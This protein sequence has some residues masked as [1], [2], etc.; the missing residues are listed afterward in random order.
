VSFEEFKNEFENQ[1]N[2]DVDFKPE[3]NFRDC[4][5]WDSL[6]AMVVV[7]FLDDRYS[8]QIDLNNLDDIKTVKDLYEYIINN[9]K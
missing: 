9:D 4:S 7:A 5:G 8:I 6:T 2:Q 1:F 3:D